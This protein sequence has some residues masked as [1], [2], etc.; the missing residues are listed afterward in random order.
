MK[1]SSAHVAAALA[2]LLSLIALPTVSSTSQPRIIADSYHSIAFSVEEDSRRAEEGGIKED[3]PEKYRTRYEAWKSEFLATT[4]GEQRWA[5]YQSN[6]NFT[7]TITI[8]KDNPHGATTGRFKWTDSG[9][10]VGAT[11]TLGSQIDEGFPEPVYYP[12]MNALATERVGANLLAATKIAHEFGH[13]RHAGSVDAKLYRLQNQ[14]MPEYRSI[15]LSNGHNTF[16]PRL[17]KLAQQMGG[18][19]A[20]VWEDREYWGEAS[21]MIYLR[22]RIHENGNRCAIFNRIRRTVEAYAGNYASRFRQIA[23]SEPSRCV[24]Q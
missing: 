7:L 1:Q 2:I 20:E 24:W 19:S 5:F 23:L 4:I 21:A 10:L 8:S 9:D 15:F 12:V 6:P 14:L 3:I 16:D 11:I 22:E 13:L 17:I 18:T